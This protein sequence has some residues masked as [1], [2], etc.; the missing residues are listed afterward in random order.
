MLKDSTIIDIDSALELRDKGAVLIDVRSPSEFADSTIPG[1]INLPLFDDAQRAEI[2]VIHKE[3]S[4]Q[5]ARLRGMQIAS[6][7]LPELI[8]QANGLFQQTRQRLVVFCWRG[9]SRSQAMTAFLQLCGLPAFQLRGGHKAF[10]QKVL[11]F[12]QLGQWGRLLVL[13]GL[14]GAGKTRILQQ[15][16]HQQLKV[17]D[18][19]GLANHRG[20]AFGA[21][22]LDLQPSQKQFEALLWDELRHIGPDQWAL[23]E[24]E[25]RHIGRLILPLRVYQALQLETTLWLETS[26]ENRIR[27]IAE[28]YDI[29]NQPPDAFV[30][31]INALK[32]RLG[33]TR[34]NEL[35]QMLHHRDWHELIRALMEDYYDPLYA[36]TKPD[37][38]IEISIDP[39]ASEQ[40]QLRAAID[41]VL[42]ATDNTTTG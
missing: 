2:G 18:L 7:R 41:R 14:T 16:Q 33:H 30:P 22:G 23:T 34:V 42:T 39:F 32:Q 8:E 6:P 17:I 27:I 10:R 28:D 21:I 1:A 9:G 25:S 20:S 36:H 37:N 12:F 15:L 19:E 35:L 11:D 38:R 26:L 29:S 5:A 4:A 13:R 40:P 31:P 3:Q 24:G